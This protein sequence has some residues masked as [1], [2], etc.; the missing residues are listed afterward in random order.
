TTLPMYYC[1]GLSVINSHLLRGAGIVLTELSVVDPCFWD[2]FR[3]RGA[4]SFAAVPYMFELLD[5]VRF[6]DLELPSLRYITQAGGR[7]DPQTVVRYAEEGQRAGWELF[8]MYGQTEATARMAYLPPPL[9]AAYPGSIGLSVPGGNFRLEP[10]PGLDDGELIYTGPNVMLGYAENPADLATG[11][12]IHELRTG[13]LARQNDSGLYEV[14]GRRS[15]FVKIVGLR[16][17]L[18]QVE[19]TLHKLGLQAACTGT[20]QKLVAAVEGSHDERLLAKTLAQSLGLPRASVQVHAV[21]RLPRLATG[22]TDYPAI[23][24]LGTE[25]E[26]PGRSTPG[27]AVPDPTAAASGADEICRIFSEALEIKDIDA[28]DTFVSL[29]GDSLSYVAASVRLEKALGDLPVN[30]HV[31]PVRD[32]VAKARPGRTRR[33]FAPLE[34]SIVLRAVAIV[35]IISTHVNLIAWPGTAHILMALAGYN[36]ARFQLSGDR[37]PRLKR[38]ARSLARVVVPTVAFI[39]A[40]MLVTDKFNYTLANLLLLNTIIGPTGW[41]DA[42]HFWFVEVLVYVLVAMMA[43]MAIPW[44]DRA[45]KRFPLGFPVGLIGAGLLARY[46]LVPFDVLHTR[47]VLWLFALGWALARARTIPQRLA[48]SAIAALTLPG[49]FDNPWRE[50]TIL[51]GIVLLAWIRALPVPTILHGPL[52]TLASASLYAYVTHW[53]IFPDLKENA[54]VLA[55]ILSVAV[56]VAYWLVSTRIMNALV[57]LRNRKARR[58]G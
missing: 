3:N 19:K 48:L 30:W 20:D 27:P 52:G 54:P 35:V 16:I 28:G 47:P 38:H 1:Y 53:V 33:L 55:V 18:G 41:T 36:F 58:A 43:L 12:T 6:T 32:L 17:D 40:V 23:L 22:K 45:E 8:V 7:L 44:A 25:P 5:R 49:Y 24:G 42:W 14:V 9:A 57:L 56:G 2:L 21:E 46:N 51:T 39:G 29:G 37:I 10:V 34:T 26:A 50:A 4:T 15:R 11:R 13:D 31:T